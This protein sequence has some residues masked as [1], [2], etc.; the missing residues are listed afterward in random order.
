MKNMQQ[1]AE[2]MARLRIIREAEQ[3]LNEKEKLK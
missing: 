3:T 1:Q 2:E